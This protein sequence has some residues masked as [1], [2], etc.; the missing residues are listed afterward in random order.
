MITVI[1]FLTFLKQKTLLNKR[2]DY[3]FRRRSFCVVNVFKSDETYY[4]VSERTVVPLDLSQK[5]TVCKESSD[6]HV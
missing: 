4:F 6:L 1:I 5:L 2:N 3:S